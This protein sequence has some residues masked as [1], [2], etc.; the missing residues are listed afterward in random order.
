MH[1]ASKFFA[2]QRKDDNSLCIVDREKCKQ[3]IKGKH[4]TNLLN[5]LKRFHA[6]QHKIV[7]EA[8]KPK[9]RQR[10]EQGESSSEQPTSSKFAK[11]DNYVTCTKV[12]KV[13]TVTFSDKTIIDACVEL[14]TKNGR[15]FHALNDSGFRKILDPI[16]KALNLTINENNIQTFIEKE[17]D[18]W[19]DHIK[20]DV[21]GN[22]S[23]IF[24][25]LKTCNMSFD[26][27]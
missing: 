18:N 26:Q 2:Y 8:M 9:K 13:A 11:M 14:V 3:T 16:T 23:S 21:K 27:F 24:L 25:R 12:N 5:H 19:V 22:F 15:A 7:I 1:P 20:S 4:G 10:E 6:Q 17:A